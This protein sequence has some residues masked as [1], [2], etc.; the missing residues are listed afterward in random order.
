MTW[1]I[2]APEWHLDDYLSGIQLDD[3]LEGFD[4]WPDPWQAEPGSL[5]V[6]LPALTGKAREDAARDVLGEATYEARVLG[7]GPSD[8]RRAMPPPSPLPHPVERHTPSFQTVRVTDVVTCDACGDSMDIQ[9]DAVADRHGR[10]DE[11]RYG[12]LVAAFVA[13]RGWL[14]AGD[15]HRCP[16]H[17]GHP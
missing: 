6:T 1:P 12:N 10:I 3:V 5:G 14:Q 2:V 17:A 16:L 7:I 15:V 8:Q 9:Y 11:A 13:H 4:Q